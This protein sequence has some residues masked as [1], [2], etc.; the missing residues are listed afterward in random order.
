MGWSCVGLS[1]QAEWSDGTA[2]GVLCAEEGLI[3]TPLIAV[4]VA[5]ALARIA[6]LSDV[7]ARVISRNGRWQ[8]WSKLVRFIRFCALRVPT[9]LSDASWSCVL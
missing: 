1:I 2:S 5:A 9:P 6:R 3:L 8:L 7:P 4:L